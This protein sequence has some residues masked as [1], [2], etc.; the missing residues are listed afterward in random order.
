MLQIFLQYLLYDQLHPVNGKRP[1]RCQLVGVLK[2]RRRSQRCQIITV[3]RADWPTEPHHHNRLRPFFPG[4]PRW[5][6]A[7]RELP[8]FMMQRKINRGRHTD[9]PAGCHSIRT[10]QCPP[11]PSPIF[12]YRPDALPDWPTETNNRCLLSSEIFSIQYTSFDNNDDNDD[13]NDNSHP[14]VVASTMRFYK[15]PVQLTGVA[16]ALL[17]RITIYQR[18]SNKVH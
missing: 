9:H 11:P 3:V 16:C 4:P 5:A 12:F 17:F 1:A 15:W 13:N 18:S 6:G 8:D 14:A 7:R 10:N 2:P